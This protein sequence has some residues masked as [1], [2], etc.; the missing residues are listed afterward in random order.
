MSVGSV[1]T[2]VDVIRNNFGSLYENSFVC[3]ALHRGTFHGGLHIR[4]ECLAVGT[5]VCCGLYVT[6]KPLV[7]VI[8]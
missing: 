7:K 6:A 8:I 4:Y 2:E 1:R 3:D 5:Q